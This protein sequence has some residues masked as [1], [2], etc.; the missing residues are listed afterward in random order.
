MRKAAI[1][2]QCAECS[3]NV[4]I[5]LTP[6]E[7]A[8]NKTAKMLK[9]VCV[10][11]CIPF[12]PALFTILDISPKNK[13]CF[14]ILKCNPKI[15]NTK[16][17]PYC[18]HH[19]DLIL[20]YFPLGPPDINLTTGLNSVFWFL[21]QEAFSPFHRQFWGISPLGRVLPPTTPPHLCWVLTTHQSSVQLLISQESSFL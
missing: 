10:W 15:F 1:Y 2:K 4:F 20:C 17:N 9:M 6:K 7:S 14:Y 19:K 3:F 11:V 16:F 13:P 8:R 18:F 12:L 21:K 5:K